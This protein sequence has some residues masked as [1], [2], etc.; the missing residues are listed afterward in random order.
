MR[1]VRIPCPPMIRGRRLHQGRV[2]RGRPALRNRLPQRSKL[3]VAQAR[4]RIWA[5]AAQVSPRTE[6]PALRLV[7]RIWARVGLAVLRRPAIP[8]GPRI[9]VRAGRRPGGTT[10]LRRATLSA[11]RVAPHRTK[12]PTVPLGRART[13][14][15]RGVGHQLR[16]Y[17]G[18]RKC[19][20]FRTTR[21][22]RARLRYC[23]RTLPRR[24]HFSTTANRSTRFWTQAYS[25][26][27]SRFMA[28]GSRSWIPAV[29]SRDVTGSFAGATRI[30]HA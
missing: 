16:P 21:S 7:R 27:D 24:R 23:H 14:I 25:S 5:Q 4:P 2:I 12:V 3:P 19:Q 26:G 1:L 30:G 9:W 20:T 18:N 22:R 8:V 29:S 13:F 28:G 10:Y 6:V 17:R 15:H 11:A